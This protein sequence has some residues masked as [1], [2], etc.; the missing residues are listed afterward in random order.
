[1]TVVSGTPYARSQHALS[2]S[3]LGLMVSMAVPVVLIILG[4]AITGWGA[5]NWVGAIVWGVIGTIAFTL[6][7]IVGAAMRMTRMDLLGMLGNTIARPGSRASKGIGLVIHHMNGA[8]LAIAW[9]YTV[10]LLGLPA[11]WATGLAWGA[12]LT[13]LALLMMTTIGSVHPAMRSGAQDDPGPAAVNFGALTPVGSLLGHLV[14]GVVLGIGYS[15][16]PLV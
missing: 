13:L 1:M 9:L 11:N 2:W 14:Y 4:I 8:I 6:F 15:V 12:V 5:I 3:A 16:L 7:S 10:A